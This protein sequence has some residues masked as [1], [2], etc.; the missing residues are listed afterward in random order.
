MSLGVKG[1]INV[2]LEFS[3]PQKLTHNIQDCGAPLADTKFSPFNDVTL[4]TKMSALS[5]DHNDDL[6]LTSYVRVPYIH[7]LLTA[8]LQ[9]E[10]I[11]FLTYT[12]LLGNWR[13][14]YHLFRD[15]PLHLAFDK[16]TVTS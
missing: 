10:W 8:Y 2:F 4:G 12:I 9:S 7:T 6:S 11:L 1:L 16:L 13:N 15:T 14:I 5:T 3:A